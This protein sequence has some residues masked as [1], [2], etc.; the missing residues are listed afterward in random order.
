MEVHDEEE[1]SF[2]SKHALEDAEHDF[3]HEEQEYF[4]TASLDDD[5]D[6][7]DDD[8][9]EARD[10]WEFV[11]QLDTST[12]KSL[13]DRN[14]A[15]IGGISLQHLRSLSFPPHTTC[16]QVAAWVCSQ[17]H[18]LPF[19]DKSYFTLLSAHVDTEHHVN[20]KA[21]V[22]VSFAWRSPWSDTLQAIRDHF[23]EQKQLDDQ[24]FVW[25]DV[26]CLDLHFVNSAPPRMASHSHSHVVNTPP[27]PAETR[28]SFQEQ[29][30]IALKE[31]TQI[32]QTIHILK[33][34]GFALVIL[35]PIL[36]MP[37]LVTRSWGWCELAAMDKLKIPFK[38]CCSMQ[39]VRG[40]INE[41]MNEHGQDARVER[42]ELDG[43]NILASMLSGLTCSDFQD[44]F[45][46]VSFNSQ[47]ACSPS[48]L[49]SE[50]DNDSAAR[51]HRIIALYLSREYNLTAHDL[52]QFM[53]GE[54]ANYYT[55]VLNQALDL[56]RHERE[57]SEI[58]H[59]SGALHESLGNF[60]LARTFYERSLDT[61]RA[62]SKPP[63]SSTLVK[64]F[65]GRARAETATE[66]V[67]AS[68]GLAHK[69]SSLASLYQKHH[70]Y[71]ESEEY[72][73]QAINTIELESAKIQAR[74]E[75]QRE[76]DQEAVEAL[77][78]LMA[79]LR[80]DVAS[81][82]Q[83]L[84]KLVTNELEDFPRGEQLYRKAL[85]ISV[86]CYGE[87]SLDVALDLVELAEC[88]CKQSKW[89][90]GLEMQRKSV[91]LVRK[92]A[93]DGEHLPNALA[94]LARLLIMSGTAQDEEIESIVEECLTLD[95]N[96]GNKSLRAKH[97]HELATCIVQA[98][99]QEADLAQRELLLLN[100]A[101]DMLQE[102]L[103]IK[104]DLFGQT[105]PLTQATAQALRSVGHKLEYQ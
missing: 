49:E 88:V 85:D 101:H 46:V 47:P 87:N 96:L 64:S 44:M 104:Q 70:R 57:V 52:D 95:D 99:S 102:A 6:F 74:L 81:Q 38:Y 32:D 11:T 65:F 92:F 78:E 9:T 33:Q 69:Q 54:L 75:R 21:S 41:I 60:D 2:A 24:V 67:V 48:P 45:H 105:D 14:E 68:L 56:A 90:Q 63:K 42:D 83:H 25:M 103:E 84:A 40:M 76:V 37:H 94:Q 26:L 97:L 51:R 30:S 53:R 13:R 39:Q 61:T 43:E 8:D 100:R 71:S 59:A 77:E 29:S 50:N 7:Y 5:W 20:E 79:F 12:V 62:L 93:G 18:D 58:Y 91:R 55:Q 31:Y 35:Q 98:V 27:G 4:A 73:R 80:Q 23:V 82:Y 28:K 36:P 66:K 3:L 19:E 86:E 10:P 89:T 34:I 15:S 1:D 22:F 16:Y 72:F 17:T